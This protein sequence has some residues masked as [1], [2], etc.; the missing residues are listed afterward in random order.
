MVKS[1]IGNLKNNTQILQTNVKDEIMLVKG[2]FEPAVQSEIKKI[3]EM[4]TEVQK[5]NA[6]QLTTKKYVLNL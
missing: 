6:E 4:K 2:L 3:N 5:I 1:Q